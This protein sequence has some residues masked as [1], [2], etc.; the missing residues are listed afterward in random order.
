[1]KKLQNSLYILT[2]G[3]YL[4]KEGETIAVYV[5]KELKQ[6]FPIHNPV[7][8]THLYSEIVSSLEWALGGR[9]LRAHNVYIK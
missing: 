4:A 6:R 9:L 2:Q 3:A 1:M 5:D 7:S 8:Y